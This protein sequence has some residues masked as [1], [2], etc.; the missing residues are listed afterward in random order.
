M[1]AAAPAHARSFAFAVGSDTVRVAL[2]ETD[3]ASGGLGWRVWGAARLLSR[4]IAEEP[5]V[6]SGQRVLELGAGCGLCGLLCARLGAT[7]VT[8][9]DAL[10][11]LLDTLAASARLQSTAADTAAPWSWRAE[12]CLIHV[13]RFLWE[14]DVLACA[15]APAEA[16]KQVSGCRALSP[17]D[18]PR[19]LLANQL[20]KATL[21]AGAAP[22]LPVGLHYDTVLASD[23]LYDWGQRV[24]LPRVLKLRIAPGGRALLVLPIRDKTLLDAFVLQLTREGLAWRAAPSAGAGALSTRDSNDLFAEGGETEPMATVDVRVWHPRAPPPEEQHRA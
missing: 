4:Q 21:E 5:S 6:A 20:R 19:S 9:T 23:V 17:A 18:D 13:R 2:H 16:E 11:G 15:D 7:S 24:P 8:L 22:A 12:Q 14:D 10:P 1:S 3:Y